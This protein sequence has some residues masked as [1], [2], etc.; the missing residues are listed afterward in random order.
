[1][2]NTA[3][4][5]KTSENGLN[6]LLQVLQTLIYRQLKKSVKPLKVQYFQGFSLYIN[7]R[8]NLKK[9]CDD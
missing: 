5:L 9:I 6:T 1:M 2:R 4:A 8:D 7:T 3:I